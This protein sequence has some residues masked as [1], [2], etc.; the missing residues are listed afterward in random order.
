M[1]GIGIET[2]NGRRDGTDVLK[3][4]AAKDG[5]EAVGTRNMEAMKAE[6]ADR[7]IA[8]KLNRATL[9]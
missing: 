9:M 2:E 7:L 6:E 5:K 4:E 8:M 3:R 1:K